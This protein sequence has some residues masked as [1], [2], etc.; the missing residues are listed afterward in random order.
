MTTIA[1]CGR[2]VAADTLA[3]NG[4]VTQAPITKIKRSACGKHVYAI[5][6]FSAWFDAWIAWFEGGAI[7]DQC[8]KMN[9]EKYDQGNFIVF[10]VG[11]KRA[12]QFGCELPYAQECFAPAA[13]GSGESY[14]MGAMLMARE[15]GAVDDVAANAVEIAKKCDRWTGGPVDVV[16]LHQIVEPAQVI[17]CAKFDSGT[18]HGPGCSCPDAPHNR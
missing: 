10:D 2:Y 11:G 4:H 18:R 1:W 17:F 12:R 5:T 9:G 6:G 3:V 16:D 8:P 15:L 7:F 14:A 13:W